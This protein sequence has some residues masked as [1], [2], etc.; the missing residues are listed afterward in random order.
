MNSCAEY[1]KL[2][3]AELLSM[4]WV[5]RGRDLELEFQ[6]A[7]D[8]RPASCRLTFTW[9]TSLRVHIDSPDAQAGFPLLWEATRSILESGA[10]A[11]RFDFGSRGTI[12]FAYNEMDAD[13]F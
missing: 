7:G 2:S 11:A 6:P 9:V 5:E 10:Y 13:G 8:P 12:E 1:S 3:D 4:R